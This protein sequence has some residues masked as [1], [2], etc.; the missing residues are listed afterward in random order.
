MSTWSNCLKVFR[1]TKDDLAD[2]FFPRYCML[3]GSRLS[4][5]EKH[6][7]LSC[8]VRLPRTDFHTVEHSYLEKLFWGILPIERAASFLYYK[9]PIRTLFLHFKYKNT[10]ELAT[11]MASLYAREIKDS[12][13]FDDIDVIVPVPLH[14]KRYL[15]RG[16]NQ[17]YYIAKGINTETG[18]PISTKVVKR[19]EN[20]VSQTKYN[21]TMRKGNVSNIFQL[22]HPEEVE[23]KHVLLVDDIVTTG[24]TLISCA[25]T[26]ADVP[27]VRISILTLG[28][29]T[30]RVALN[31]DE[32]DNTFF[33]LDT[34][35]LSKL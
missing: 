35:R 16:Y 14:W 29:A 5:Q 13:F 15:K 4:W 12:G 23:G 10:P 32:V 28:F 8:N 2:F 18:I 6:I 20:N 22:T 7:C 3:C 30:Q 1:Q 11:Y 33:S 17:C 24:S 34:E 9:D 21:S 25:E 19:V 27:G 26:F 31:I